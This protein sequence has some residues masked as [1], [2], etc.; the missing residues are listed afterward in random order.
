MRS[1][2]KIQFKPRLSIAKIGKTRFWTGIVLGIF[3]AFVLYS[4]IFCFFEI[5]NLMRVGMSLDIPLQSETAL[6]FEHT[7][8][9][10]IAIALG[11]HT[12]V[13]YW[14]SQPTFHF[15][16]IQKQVTLR[17]AN[18][19]LFVEYLCWYMVAVFLR[20]W[21]AGHFLIGY[22][23]YNAYGFLF[24][25]IPAYLFLMVWTEV[26]RF[27]NVWKWKGYSFVISLFCVISLSFIDLSEYRYA[28]T[29]YE[30]MYDEELFYVNN[31][32]TNAKENYGIDYEVET[33]TTLKK[34]KTGDL[35]Q[36]L[37]Q[38]KQKFETNKKVRLKDII[39]QKILIHN[40]KSAHFE[41]YDIQYYPDPVDVYAQ[42][43]KV[44]PTSHEATELVHIL[45]EFYQLTFFMSDL[46]D[47]DGKSPT[48]RLK[49]KVLSDA[50]DLYY[51]E[52]YKH[53]ITMRKQIRV[54]I[55]T[56]AKQETY[57]HP[58]ITQF[59]ASELPPP[60]PLSDR[61]IYKR[62]PELQIKIK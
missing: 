8:L 34:L 61:T 54:L 32:I 21:A 52:L 58:F 18:Y 19:A 22:D 5:V 51:H 56:L 44:A 2:K 43:K 4:F 6:Q 28:T 55:Y 53:F 30:N 48:F 49:T 39:L 20:D 1:P 25:M 40:F 33:I 47:A 38:T 3:S 26:A 35:Q 11:N 37:L 45:E 29:V 27:F 31:E 17:I 14:F 15:Q 13:R 42:L 9:L 23:T 59:K 57:T 62:F 36:L 7:L 16:K 41:G 46:K 10:A 12:M 50:N 60:I 24:Y